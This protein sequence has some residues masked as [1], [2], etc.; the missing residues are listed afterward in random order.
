MGRPFVS[1]SGY[2]NHHSFARVQSNVGA[3]GLYLAALRHRDHDAAGRPVDV[4]DAPT[5]GWR[6]WGDL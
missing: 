3:G 6:V 2:E 4:G 1:V 5:A